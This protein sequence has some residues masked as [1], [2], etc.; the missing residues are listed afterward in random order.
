MNE[1]FKDTLYNYQNIIV[2]DVSWNSTTTRDYN[3]KIPGNTMIPSDVGLLNAYE[4]YLSYKKTTPEKD[5]LKMGDWWLLT[6]YSTYLIYYVS[7]YYKGINYL[8]GRSYSEGI[9]PVIVLKPDIIV[10]D[11]TGSKEEPYRLKD[12][13]QI[14]KKNEKINSRVSGEYRIVEIMDNG[15]TKLSSYYPAMKDGS[16]YY[17]TFSS[18]AHPVYAISS[19]NSF[20]NSTWVTPIKNYLVEGEYYT[21]EVGS[22][23]SKSYKSAICYDY[24]TK[25]TTKTCTKSYAWTGLVGLP[26]LG[27][28]FSVSEGGNSWL[29]TPSDSASGGIYA[30]SSDDTSSYNSNKYTEPSRPSITLKSE[31][32]ITGGDGMS[33]DTAYTIALPE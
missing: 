31:V 1:D 32:I 9:R 19:P 5:Y 8:D 30:S 24:N 18:Q 23:R 21:S 25:L 27:E 15:I 14:G 4:Y 17:A 22:N 16:I 28:M 3:V 10:C 12:D 29:I 6:P 13:I 7:T 33:I 2:K 26:R 20:L 11:G